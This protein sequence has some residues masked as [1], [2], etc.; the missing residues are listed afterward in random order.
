MK[1][2]LISVVVLALLILSGCQRR[3]EPQ[4]ESQSQPKSELPLIVAHR[5]ASHLAPE[6][7][8]AAFNLAWEQ[9]AD[10][11]EGDFYLSND[12][13]IVCHHDKTTKK[14]A[15]LDI[16]VSQQSFDALRQLDVG[17][18]KDEKWAGERIPTLDEVLATVPDGK[19]V[20]IE[21]KTD[22]RIVP[23]LAE[24]IESADLEAAQM[25]IIAFDEDVIAA[26][27]KRLPHIKAYWLS[28]FDETDSGGWEPTIDEIIATAQRINADGVDLHANLDVIDEAFVAALRAADLEFHAYTID[29]TDVAQRLIELGVDSITTN[30]PGWLR[31]QLGPED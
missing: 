2:S 20:L 29:E 10:C 22:E 14:T 21:I 16:S 7:T 11:I 15:G 1:R 9:D 30:R 26:A 8:L 28:G 18:W 23:M 4:A 13:V 27:K 6:N 24:I 3:D 12:G 19:G 17:S 5:G 31:E 25:A